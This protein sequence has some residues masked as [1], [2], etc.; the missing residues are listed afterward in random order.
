MKKLFFVAALGVAGLMSANVV[1][2]Q[3]LKAEDVKNQEQLFKSKTV[4]YSWVAII[5]P[6]GKVYY[7]AYESYANCSMDDLYGDIAYFN[8]QQCGG[9]Y[10][11]GYA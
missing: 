8:A 9:G 6:C 1:N 10:Q 7:L 11:G 4:A 2:K 5:S 3:E